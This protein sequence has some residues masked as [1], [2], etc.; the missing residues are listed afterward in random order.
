[1]KLI[2]VLLRGNLKDCIKCNFGMLYPI[3][4]GEWELCVKTIA[5]SYKKKSQSDPNPPNLDKFIRLTCN[6]VE[7]LSFDDSQTQ[8]LVKES[9]LAI[10]RLEVKANEK[11]F[12]EFPNRDFFLISSPSQK[13]QIN[14]SD[15][16]GSTFNDTVQQ[17]LNVEILI[18]FRR[19]S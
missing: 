3:T 2:P 18:L 11:Y 17:C 5:V 12:Y 13:F 8:P 14:I 19:R 4:N 1:M 9:V 7:S 10:L 16:E 6:Y 15:T